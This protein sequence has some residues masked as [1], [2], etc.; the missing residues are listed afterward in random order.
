MGMNLYKKTITMLDKKSTSIVMDNSL[1]AFFTYL[2]LF[3]V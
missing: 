1:I 2:L 3:A